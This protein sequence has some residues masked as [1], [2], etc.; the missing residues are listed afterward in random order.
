MATPQR[1]PCPISRECFRQNAK[2]IVAQIN[3]S[4]IL[5]DAKEF[6]TNSLGWFYN[7]KITV[8]INDVPVPCTSNLSLVISNS[9]ELPD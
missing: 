8:M 9:K 2:P 7:G 1:T 4:T 6:S 3:G 5:L